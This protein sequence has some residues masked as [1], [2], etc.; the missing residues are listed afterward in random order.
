MQELAI[1]HAGSRHFGMSVG[2]GNV[3]PRLFG[4]KKESFVCL[5]VNF[6][7]VNWPTNHSAKIVVPQEQWLVRLTVSNL[8]A[9]VEI[10]VCIQRIIAEELIDAAVQRART[11]ADYKIDWAA[12]RSSIFGIILATEYFDF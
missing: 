3:P 7:N 4:E 5:L 1:E 9:L 2:V 10:R 8:R 6:G 12:G 11:R